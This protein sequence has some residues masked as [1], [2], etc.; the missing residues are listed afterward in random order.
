MA[1]ATAD[2]EPVL[3]ELAADDGV[4]LRAFYDDVLAPAF[5]ADELVAF[6]VLAARVASTAT[7]A[8]VVV[9]RRGD[10]PVL[11]GTVGE[12]FP[13]SRTLLLTYLVVRPGQRTRGLGSWLV[14]HA[15]PRWID[16]WDPV[17]GVGEVEN[18][19]TFPGAGRPAH[20]RI[21]LYARFPQVR[22]AV[23]EYTQPRL[24][25]GHDRVGNMVLL[26]FHVSPQIV[27]PGPD[28]TVHGRAVREFLAE[29]YALTEGPASLDDPEVC[30]L[31]DGVPA[32]PLHLPRLTAAALPGHLPVPRRP[33][34][35]PAARPG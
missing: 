3:L 25:D 8:G 5:P 20:H 28:L 2:D 27:V 12:F 10:G 6:D 15:V 11:G 24:Q 19:N 21:T 32:G 30:R 26:A 9:A 31:L 14:R 16:R 23:P 35:A 29:Y 33:P 7:P 18:P 13:R 1:A 17:L 22:V 34:D 4:L